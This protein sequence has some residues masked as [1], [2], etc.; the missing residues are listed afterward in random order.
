MIIIQDTREQDPLIFMSNDVE[1]V[2]ETLETG[3][4]AVRFNGEVAPIRIERKSIADLF[5]SFN[6]DNYDR[7]RDKILRAKEL[8]LKYILAIEGSASEVRKGHSYRKD[9]E[10]HDV[11][12]TG[13]SQVRQLMTIAHKYGVEVWFTDGRRDMAFRIIEYFMAYD[14][15][16]K[17]S[18]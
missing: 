8:G 13:L 18:E 15:F 7:E 14:R 12:K 6:G 2:K 10:I 4:Y 9:G 5:T 1:V 16:K 3:D 17:S 11:K